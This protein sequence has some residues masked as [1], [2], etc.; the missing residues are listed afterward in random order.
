MRSRYFANMGIMALLSIAFLFAS[1]GDSDESQADPPLTASAFANECVIEQDGYGPVGKSAL[2]VETLVSGLR[3]PWGIGFISASEFL[4]TE[5]PGRVRMVRDGEI[6]PRPVLV[7]PAIASRREGGLL[8]LAMHPQFGRNRLFYVYYTGEKDGREVNRIAR[9][10]LSDDG[11]QA[12]FDRIIFDNIEAGLYHDGGRIRFGPDGMLYVG[13]GDGRRPELSQDLNSPSGKILRLTPDGGVPDDN[14]FSGNPA[15]VLGVR[16]VQAFDWFNG[17][18]LI[19]ADHG[20]TGELGRSGGDEVSAV[21]AGANLGWPNTWRC[22]SAEGI[23]RPFLVWDQA[24]PPGGL[25]YYT[26][27]FVPEW[28]GSVLIAA[29]RSE[30]LIRIEFERQGSTVRMKQHEVYLQGNYGRLREIVQAPDGSI[31]VTTSNCDK[32]GRCGASGDLILRITK[33]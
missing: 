30:N 10:R 14:P 31:Y 21:S 16:N 7:I 11:T 17:R 22:A 12:T 18:T 13:T 6:L 27:N 15:Y 25:V 33:D 9:Y 32:R 1:C 4:V 5:R 23:A 20:P 3:V 24:V 26:G 8:G 28:K 29:L 2:R 19:V